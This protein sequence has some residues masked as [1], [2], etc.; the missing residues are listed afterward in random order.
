MKAIRVNEFGGREKLVFEEVPLPE[1]KGDLVRVKVEAAGLNFIEI[2]HRRGWY[3]LKLPFTPG[4]EF[5]GTV[6]AVG[7]QVTDL[8]PGDRVVTA[9]GSGSYAEYSAAPAGKLVPVPEG[10]ST[11]LAAAVLFQGI[12]AHY[13]VRDTWPIKPGDVI[14]VHAAAGGVGLLLVQMAKKFGATIISTVSEEEKASLATEAG[15]DHVIVTSRTDFEEAVKEITGGKLVD[16]VYDGVGKDTFLKG[17]NCIR[18][19]GMMVLFGQASGNVDPV[20]P[21]LL[22]QKGSLY[23]TRPTIGTHMRTREELLWRAGEI[24]AWVKSGELKVRID[25]EF[26]LSQAAEAQEYLEERRSKGKVLLVP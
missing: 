3:P 26:P 23:L 15:A 1:V 12:T 25:R 21:L 24:F 22:S 11:R 13:L 2:Y 9:S 14:L 10:V 20:D 8:K 5:A 7:P 19:R 18:P 16:V 17:L 4:A 6:D